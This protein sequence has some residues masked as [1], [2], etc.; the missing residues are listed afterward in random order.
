MWV[1]GEW[2]NRVT[3]WETGCWNSLTL[4]HIHTNTHND[5]PGDGCCAGCYWT[6]MK[7]GLRKGMQET[8]EQLH[9]IRK[10]QSWI[11]TKILHDLIFTPHFNLKHPQNPIPTKNRFNSRTQK[12][13]SCSFIDFFSHNLCLSPLF[14]S[15]S[16]C[17][18][19]LNNITHSASIFH[20]RVHRYTNALAHL[21]S[22]SYSTVTS[23]A[24]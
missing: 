13:P 14:A 19:S 8:Q 22:H 4:T 9:T 1:R 23:E 20:P 18:L 10:A 2:G 7:R 16:R 6:G 12:L 3:Q 21:R 11:K 24:T 5:G 15:R 17:E